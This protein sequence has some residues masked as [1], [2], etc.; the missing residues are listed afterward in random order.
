MKIFWRTHDWNRVRVWRKRW[1]QDQFE[2][3][4]ADE[5]ECFKRGCERLLIPIEEQVD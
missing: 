3:F 1:A 4:T 2:V 5:F